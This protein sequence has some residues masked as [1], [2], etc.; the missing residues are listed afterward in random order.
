MKKT[1]STPITKTS[2]EPVTV[3]VL[4][5]CASDMTS[6]NGFKWPE[7][8]SIE[9]PDW[10]P[11]A[12]CGN[13]LHGFLWGEGNGELANWDSDAK[14]LVCR[15]PADSVVDLHGKVKFPRC[16]VIH[17]G[18]RA[19]ATAFI[20]ANGAAGC[21][22]VGGTSTSGDRG[23]ST[24]GDRGTSTSG[25]GGTSTSGCGGVIAITYWN[26]KRYK[27]RIGSVKDEDGEG[28]LLPNTPY[29]LNERGEFVAVKKQEATA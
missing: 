1:K 9:A 28:E 8:G 19:S 26:G 18:D 7:S 23:T 20:A 29:Q 11:K 24:S 4:R 25:V 2:T 3:L 10:N 6:Y 15:V 27:V 17:C 13:G 5:T 21:A 22:I 14:W 12:E 16:E